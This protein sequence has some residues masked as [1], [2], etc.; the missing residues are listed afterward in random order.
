MTSAQRWPFSFAV[1]HQLRGDRVAV[2]L[3]TD[4]S[5]SE[6]VP[7]LRVERHE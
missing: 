3:V 4:Q 1:A 2:G 6:V 7:G 5:A